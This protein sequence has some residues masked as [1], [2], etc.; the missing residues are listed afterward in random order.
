MYLPAG[1]GSVYVLIKLI[2]LN[3]LAGRGNALK[4][5]LS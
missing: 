3:S 4:S 2:Q 5:V 1:I